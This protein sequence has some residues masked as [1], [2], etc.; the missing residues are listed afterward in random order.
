MLAVGSS[1][2]W[3]SS[4]VIAAIGLVGAWLASK[5]KNQHNEQNEKLDKL[6]GGH[7]QLLDADVMHDHK[8]NKVSK[9]LKDHGRRI[10]QIESRPQLKDGK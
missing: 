3:N 6:L 5:G 9:Q 1:E 8:L 7:R 10:Q 4:V 2:F